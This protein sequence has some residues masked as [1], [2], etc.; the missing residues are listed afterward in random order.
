[1]DESDHNWVWQLICAYIVLTCKL[2]HLICCLSHFFYLN[3]IF[4]YIDAK[5]QNDGS[6]KWDFLETINFIW[7]P[8]VVFPCDISAIIRWGEIEKFKT[9]YQKLKYVNLAI[10]V[11][12]SIIYFINIPYKLHIKYIYSCDLL[13]LLNI[14]VYFSIN[15]LAGIFHTCLTCFLNH[16]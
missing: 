9:Y 4:E 5:P 15:F 3:D 13:L 12:I 1:M 8:E 2:P 6:W 11:Y 7:D 16:F 10:L 14:K